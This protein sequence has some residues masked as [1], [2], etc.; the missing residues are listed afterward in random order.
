MYENIK[1]SFGGRF[2]SKG[3]WKHPERVQNTTEL[4][5]MTS[6]E[7][8]IRVGEVPY[9]ISKGDVMCINSGVPHCGFEYSEGVSFIW[10]HFTGALTEMRIPVISSPPDTA[11]LELISRQL[12]HYANTDGYPEEA[13]NYLIRLLI[14]ELTR[15][16][17]KDGTTNARTCA[18]ICH[19][20]ELNCELPLRTADVSMHF[21][22][23]K[24][25]LGR[26][27]KAEKNCTVKEYIDSVR[28]KKIKDSLMVY[29]LTLQEISD[30]FGFSDYKYF[31][32]FF[33]Y[34]EGISPSEFRRS[35]YNTVVNNT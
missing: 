27:F 23:N 7:A 19:F 34:H 17:N 31:L 26:I 3:L 1:F 21:N 2:T 25:Y 20:I 5:I 30:K 14:I 33:K 6:G 11:R 32:K 12:L 16:V 8:H 9:S 24:D 35:F 18:A 13:A 10:L 28:L 22:Y 4:I 15:N 29:T